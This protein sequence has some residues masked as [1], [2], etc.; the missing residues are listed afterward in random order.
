MSELFTNPVTA[1]LTIPAGTTISVTA[2]PTQY[3]GLRAIDLSA[4]P[5]ET[6]PSLVNHG[7]VEIT[8][9]GNSGIAVVYIENFS[10]VLHAVVEND[11]VMMASAPGD[12]FYP[13]FAHGFWANSWSPDFINTG[14]VKI[15]GGYS[16]IAVE[17]WD[18]RFH[19]DNSGLIVAQGGSSA[20]GI[21][22]AN[23]GV[24]SNNG[25]ISITSGDGTQAIGVSFPNGHGEVDNTGTISASDPNLSTPYAYGVALFPGG[26]NVV[27]NHGTI[28]GDYAIYETS[29]FNAPQLAGAHI[30]NYAQMS[31]DVQLAQDPDT[32]LNSGVMSGAISLGAG[33]D[34]YNGSA[35]TV[36]G[37][38]SGNDGDDVLVGGAA[39][40]SL[41]GNAGNDTENGGAGDDI[42][43]GGKDNDSQTGDAGNDIVWGNLGNDTL[44]GGAGNDQV[45]G[46]QGDDSI[47]GGA[48]NDF[49]SGDRGNDTESGGPGADIFHGSQDAGIDKVLDFNLAE[50]DR[51]QL[52]PGTTYTVTQVGADTVIDMG[53]ANQMILVGVQMSTLTGAWI[54]EG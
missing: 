13:G 14:T 42:V 3:E 27:I 45:R 41:Q 48:G 1:P 36:T 47:S 33:N 50:G 12:R 23:G 38:V 11:G 39:A 49:I 34:T 44:D 9:V 17:S 2:D 18:S 52:D 15:L 29:S 16:A 31:G 20:F 46:G 4:R 37:L 51:V 54:F 8:A 22:A 32:I 40:D 19:V 6:E 28:S 35:G 24:V 21:Y 25:T 7:D 26:S 10:P 5:G 30:E 43:V 53:G